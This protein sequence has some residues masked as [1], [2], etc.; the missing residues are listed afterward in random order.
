MEGEALNIT[1]VIAGAVAGFV[2]GAVI[3]HPKVL[4]TIWANGSRVPA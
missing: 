4:G 3:Y 2:F 1:A